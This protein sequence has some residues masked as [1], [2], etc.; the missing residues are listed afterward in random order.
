MDQDLPGINRRKEILP[1]KWHQ[2]ERRHGTSQEPRGRQLRTPENAR[3]KSVVAVTDLLK[4]MLESELETLQRISRWS[5]WT[6]SAVSQ[7]RHPYQVL[8]QRR[9]QG[10]GQQERSDEGKNDGFR[11]RPEQIAGYAAKLEHRCEHDAHADQR[12]EGRNN[13]LLGAIQDSRFKRLA[14][15]Q[16]PVDVLERNSALIDQD[17]DRKREPPERHHIDRFAQPGQRGE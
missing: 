2:D 1:E 11:Q 10:A 8:G 15:L 5:S 9:D 17:P 4:P 6:S 7:M 3:E 12:D 16:V 13:D 14:L